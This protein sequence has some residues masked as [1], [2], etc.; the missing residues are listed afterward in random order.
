MIYLSYIELLEILLSQ[1]AY[2][3]IKQNESILF[4]LIPELKVSKGFNQNNKWHNYD[5][6][7][8][9]L[10]VVKNVESN[11]CLRLSALFHDIGKPFVYTLDKDGVG[12]F[13]NH[14]NKS[15]EIFNKY[16]NH[17]ELYEQEINLISNL[18][19]YHDLNVEKL[20]LYELREMINKIGKDNI[21]LLFSLKRA[22]LLAQSPEF[23]YLLDNINNQED[24]LVKSLKKQ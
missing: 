3:T 12:H 23:H 15:L 19:F 22:D 1:D 17:F 4:G 24:K 21:H 9:I 16:M 6:Y 7:E 13:F 20:N 14:W 10:H 8:H 5:V 18:I 2:D 11:K